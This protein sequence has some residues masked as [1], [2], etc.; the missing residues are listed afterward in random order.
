[1]NNQTPEHIQIA[2]EIMRV[3]QRLER[4]GN[5]LFKRADDKA[6]NEREY[7]QA[8][9]QEMLKLKAEG[10]PVTLIADISRGNVAHLKYKRD[11]S[12]GQFKAAVE[13]VGALKTVASMLQTVHK[14]YDNL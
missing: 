9:A 14:K 8:L 3:S 2:K 4:S 1:M 12:D 10:F 13:A 7:R 5:A 11:L 6:E